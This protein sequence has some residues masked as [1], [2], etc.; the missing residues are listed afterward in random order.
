[1]S[2]P[3]RT[4]IKY[5]IPALSDLGSTLCL[6]IL[7]SQAL[8]WTTQHLTENLIYMVKI[9]LSTLTVWTGD[10]RKLMRT[11]RMEGLNSIK[12]FYS[13]CWLSRTTSFNDSYST[14]GSEPS[15]AGRRWRKCHTNASPWLAPYHTGAH[16]SSAT[17]NNQLSIPWNL[18]LLA[19]L[20]RNHW[21]A[22]IR[23]C[24]PRLPPFSSDF[25]FSFSSPVFW[26]CLWWFFSLCVATKLKFGPLYQHQINVLS[27]LVPNKC[28]MQNTGRLWAYKFLGM[29]EAVPGEV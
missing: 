23:S 14:T 26:K 22:Q 20:S 21:R 13:L 12:G 6:S 8:W 18:L 4:L 10:Y 5:I 27:S 24:S 11:R 9:F 1:M 16:N 29:A 17:W 3:Y 28:Q 2:T 15:Q 19:A 7:H 25:S